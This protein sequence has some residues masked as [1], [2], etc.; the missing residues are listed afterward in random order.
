MSQ[1]IPIFKDVSRL[2]PL[3]C[4]KVSQDGPNVAQSIPK[5]SKVPLKLFDAVP[6]CHKVFQGVQE[7]HKVSH[8]VQECPKV[9]QGVPRC[10][11]VL[12]G[13]PRC[14]GVS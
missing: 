13:V 11:R 4:P 5:S 8:G 1:I 10:P 6:E 7:G 3:R 12:Q 9:S 2:S 14:P